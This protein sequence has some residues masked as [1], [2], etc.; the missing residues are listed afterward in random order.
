MGSAAASVESGAP[1]MNSR[2]SGATSRASLSERS[3]ATSVVNAQM[4]RCSRG[5][6]WNEWPRSPSLVLTMI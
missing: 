3:F 2:L 1:S 5:R 6:D 4:E